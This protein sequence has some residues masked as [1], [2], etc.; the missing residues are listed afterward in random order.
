MPSI[1][2]TALIHADPDAIFDLISRVE[3][4]P[5][6][7]GALQDVTKIGGRTY[8]WVAKVGGTTLSWDSVITKFARPH[9][10]AWRSIRGFTNSGAYELTPV[11][12]GTLVTMRIAYDFHNPLLERLLAPVVN[13]VARAGAADI[14]AKVKARLEHDRAKR[15][16]TGSPI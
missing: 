11:P 12:G 15:P 9:R 13:A 14:L 8:R 7:S 4:F 1:T 2:E 5:A 3:E 16:T 6:Y 10:I